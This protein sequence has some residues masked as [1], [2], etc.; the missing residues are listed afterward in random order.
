MIIHFFNLKWF[1]HFCNASYFLR[2]YTNTILLTFRTPL[3]KRYDHHNYVSSYIDE[4]GE[5]DRGLGTASCQLQNAGNFVC[6][7]LKM[8]VVELRSIFSICSKKHELC[9]AGEQ[10]SFCVLPILSWFGQGAGSSGLMVAR[11]FRLCM[12]SFM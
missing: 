2:I 7:F 4:E 8:C 3:C 9:E 1:I 6:R 5:A 11:V 12:S 10:G